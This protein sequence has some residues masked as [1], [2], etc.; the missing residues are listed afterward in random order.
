[1]NVKP[2]T[3]DFF[4]VIKDRTVSDSNA[5]KALQ[6][7]AES[8][9]EYVSRPIDIPL[10]G[11]GWSH[12]YNC[13]D[14]GS[15]VNRIDRHHHQCPVCGKIWSG[16][17]WD[18]TAIANEHWGYSRSCRD[19]AILFAINWET[20]LAVYA[21][22]ILM[23]YSQ[24]YDTYLFHDK[25]GGQSISG[26][27]VQC[28]TLSES[29]WIIPLAQ[30][31]HI[32]K[33]H[34]ILSQEEQDFIRDKLFLPVVEVIQGNPK[35]KSNW[36]S[37]HNAAKAA[38]AAAVTDQ[39]LFEEAIYDVNNGF[40]FQM[41]NSLGDD[42]FWFEGSWG[43]HFY[44]LE[45]H[46]NTV[47][48]ALSFSLPL[49]ENKRFR[50]MFSAPVK[51]MY[52]KCILPAVHDS[53]EVSL[54]KYVQLYEF[55]NTFWG[56][57][58]EI[59]GTVE[60]DTLFSLLF[61]SE[62]NENDAEDNTASLYLI[63]DLKTAGMLFIKGND[64][65]NGMNQEI[66]LDYGEHGGAHG[67][68]DKLNLLYYAKGYNW[69]TDAGTVPYG[70]PLYKTWFKETIAHNTL[71]VDGTSQKATEGMLIKI[72]ELAEAIR[73]QAE[74]QEAYPG[75]VMKREVILTGQ[76]LID[77]CRI[78][79]DEEKDVDWVIHTPGLPIF[80]ESRIVKYTE[81]PSAVLGDKDGYQHL[82]SIR[83]VQSDGQQWNIEWKRA[84]SQCPDQRFQACGCE[85]GDPTEIFLA[86]SPAMA[87]VGKRSSLIR[88][89][90][91]VRTACF[92][93]VFRAYESGDTNMQLFISDNT[94]QI[95]QLKVV[96]GQEVHYSIN[97]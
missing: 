45:A 11:G 73:I 55:S 50:S 86:E 53:Q 30:A 87:S 37:H 26:G 22:K 3:V 13:P 80:D 72:D 42:G 90:K 71:V 25:M 91:S 78:T 89:K 12:N 23:F 52:P 27:K 60:R 66:V 54:F 79:S 74:V 2:W 29:T 19:A 38:I 51:C 15:Y 47:L 68:Y 39:I 63:H 76:V 81:A 48:A 61:W 5:G 85:T 88:R 75:V 28:Q 94:P 4:K 21:K 83:K 97:F 34:H 59:I 24:H 1:M 43:Y 84:D 82:R 20:D 10:I 9:E 8:V 16:S 65:K 67:H 49:Y 77:I 14:D 40:M 95:R 44:A 18:D 33:E 92:V 46:V 7:L 35:G 70:N 93:T 62:V 58:K 32:L 56:F 41:E 36:Q 69:L 57:G 6:K 96:L 64:K 31:F 17:P